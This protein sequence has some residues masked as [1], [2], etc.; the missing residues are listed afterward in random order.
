[1]KRR[2]INVYLNITDS[3]QKETE[4]KPDTGVYA[5]ILPDEKRML[6]T[7]LPSEEEYPDI[8]TKLAAVTGFTGYAPDF[9]YRTDFDA[10]RDIIDAIRGIDVMTEKNFKIGENY[11]PKGMNKM[12]GK[13]AMALFRKKCATEEEQLQIRE[14]IVEGFLRKALKGPSLLYDYGKLYNVVKN[15]SETNVTSAVVKKLAGKNVKSAKEWQIIK[16][17]VMN[18]DTEE[19]KEKAREKIEIFNL[20]L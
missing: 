1:M 2:K 8:E 7:V 12:T 3:R 13:P 20:D 19:V 18:T 17:Y 10:M 5:T 11:Y 15:C 4:R 16:Q 14:S 6:I 9:Y